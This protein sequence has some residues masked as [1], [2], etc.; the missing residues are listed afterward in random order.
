MINN[1]EQNQK[2]RVF[3][4]IQPS[5][6]LTIGN[7]V[8]AISQWLELQKKYDC[9]FS[10]VDYHAITVSQDPEI[11]RRRIKEITK[12][13]LAFGLGSR[14]S[15]IFQQSA[16]PEHT[17]LAWILNCYGAKVADLN[18][19]TQFKDKAGKNRESVSV[20]LYD[21]P[22]LMAAD[23][24]LYDTSIVPVGEDQ[25]QHVELAR[26][27]ARRF[28]NKFG[29]VFK[30]PE[31][32]LNKEGARIM[33]LQD[34]SKKM[35]KSDA[36]QSAFIRLL[37]EPEIVRQKIKKA[38]TDSGSEITYDP[39]HKPAIANLLNIYSVLGGRSI[40]DLVKKYQGQGYGRFKEE[41]A[42]T[43]VLF[44]NNFQNNYKAISDQEVKRV[45]ENGR[46][47]VAN[48]VRKKIFE[49]KKAIGVN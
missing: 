24:L 47:H 36:N 5:G 6:S 34:S 30:I 7:Y 17:E 15:I 13:Y 18:K 10:V 21:Y 46:H 19:M 43:V 49:V 35:S 25:K 28:N 2:L 31:A 20:G 29:E 1:N 4:G 48:I 32:V 26:T 44:L 22:V 9:L 12:I 33:S 16:V 3:S 27:I 42:E 40:I 41:L 45:L 37:D 39:D 38:V 8:G 14:N 23:I 11:L